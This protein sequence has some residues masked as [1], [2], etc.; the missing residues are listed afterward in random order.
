MNEEETSKIKP[1]Y[2]PYKCV[3]CSGYGSFSHG[4]VLC[5]ACNGLGYLKVPPKDEAEEEDGQA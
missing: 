2:I 4:T 5:Q 3:I 1:Q